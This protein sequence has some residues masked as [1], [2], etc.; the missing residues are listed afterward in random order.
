[1][2]RCH[3]RSYIKGFRKISRCRSQKHHFNLLLVKLIRIVNK[4]PD[5]RSTQ[6]FCWRCDPTSQPDPSY[7]QTREQ[8]WAE[9]RMSACLVFISVLPKDLFQVVA[10]NWGHNPA[11]NIYPAKSSDVIRAIR[12]CSL[13]F[14]WQSVS[15]VVLVAVPV[16][17]ICKDSVLS[18]DPVLL[19][20]LCRPN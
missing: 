4:I 14:L 17:G 8:L 7:Q 19:S 12:R 2:Q 18:L 1:M 9:G 11:H 20:G 3:N 10:F 13:N 6:Q 16:A 15:T 5:S